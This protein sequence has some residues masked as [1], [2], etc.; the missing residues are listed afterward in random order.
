MALIKNIHLLTDLDPESLTMMELA[1]TEHKKHGSITFKIVDYSPQGVIIQIVQGKSAAGAYHN[2]KRLIEIT[3]ETFDRFF[4][5]K[6]IKVHAIQYEQPEAAEVDAKW[7]SDRM[8][9]THTKL[10]DIAKETGLDYTSLSALV[11]GTRPLSQTTQAM[12]YYYFL[13][14]KAKK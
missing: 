13:S 8:L 11:N 5:G 10:K 4:T 14:K 3:H 9:A 6:K 2:Q 7:I 12:F 1:A